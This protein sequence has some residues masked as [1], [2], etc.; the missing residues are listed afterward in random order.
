MG[1]SIEREFSRQF[2]MEKNR[3]TEVTVKE[4]AVYC[5]FMSKNKD[6]WISGQQSLEHDF[7]IVK[8]LG[9]QSLK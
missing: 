1:D 7:G 8:W 2:F 9:L 6:V 4:L 3:V 5:V